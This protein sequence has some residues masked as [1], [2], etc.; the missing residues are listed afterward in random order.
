MLASF[1]ATRPV[2]ARYHVLFTYTLMSALQGMIWALPGALSNTYTSLYG[3][4][5]DTINLLLNYGPILYLVVLAPVSLHLDRHGIRG[6]TLL[7]VALVCVANALRL[8]AND[9]SP[10]SVALLHVSYI[11][12]ASAGPAA[13]GI[14]SKL[15]ADWFPP[16]ERTLACAIAALGN[17]SGA[18]ILYLAIAA[19]FPNP[20]RADNFGLNVFLAALGAVNAVA[21]V[22]FF[23]SHPAAAPSASAALAAGAASRVT[24]RALAR[25]VGRL[26]RNGPYVAIFAAYALSTGEFNCVNSLLPQAIG[27]LGEA[28]PQ[29]V[30][31]WVSFASNAAAVVTGV[32]VAR[33]TG[34]A[35]A[36]DAGAQKRVLVGALATVGVFVLAFAIALA[37]G[38]VAPGRAGIALVAGFYVAAGAAQG[39]AIPLLFEVAAEHTGVALRS[40]AA[41]DGDD[42]GDGGGGK[43][44]V[45]DDADIAIPVG[46]MLM[47]L[48][49]ASNLVS[50]VTFSMPN[51]SFFI[52][53]NWV[54]AAI[55]LG[56]AALLAAVLPASSPR[57]E[58]D[59]AADDGERLPAAGGGE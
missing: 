29:G 19:A 16:E 31:G 3:L 49:A 30:A 57:Y 45:G 55:F 42:D 26:M 48:T 51:A 6:Q 22:L 7:A 9:A 11:L 38:G 17:S 32:L 41:G 47:L 2:A 28:N 58:F 40:R 24:L 23:P 37:P 43:G 50:L 5:G 12:N 34:G 53:A 54:G 14:P 46:T 18:L 52:W 27:N 15:A 4:S 25:A 8:L 21:A 36:A 35:M 20:T 39:A 1:Y 44:G 59:T 56:G 13:M 10:A 33:V